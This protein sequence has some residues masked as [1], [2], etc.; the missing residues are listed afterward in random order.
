MIVF[1]EENYLKKTEIGRFI[2]WLRGRPLNLKTRT[3]CFLFFI[4]FLLLKYLE[5]IFFKIQYYFFSRYYRRSPNRGSHSRRS[6]RY[7][8]HSRSRSRSR[9][10]EHSKFNNH[11]FQGFI[12]IFY[13]LNRQTQKKSITI[14]S[15]S[16]D[17]Q[18]KKKKKFFFF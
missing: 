11:Y 16:I 6:P 14:S 17:L 15:L 12:F 18:Q 7:S 8:R 10:Y 13:F 4:S 5:E 1:L 2:E 9:S 3:I